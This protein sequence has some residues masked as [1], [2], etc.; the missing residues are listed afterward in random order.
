MGHAL[1][2]TIL[3]WSGNMSPM[4]EHDLE[5]CGLSIEATL[6][7]HGSPY[8]QYWGYSVVKRDE[9]D[10]VKAVHGGFM[11]RQ[12]AVAFAHTLIPPNAEHLDHS[13]F[14]EWIDIGGEG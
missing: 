9:H 4:E 2:L 7:P 1:F 14:E 5:L 3:V 8:G 12:D 10:E 11:K 6:H 13:D